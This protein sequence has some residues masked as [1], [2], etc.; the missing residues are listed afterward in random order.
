MALPLCLRGRSHGDL[1]RYQARANQV[2]RLLQGQRH[3]TP[4]RVIGASVKA[5]EHALSPSAI[6]ESITNVT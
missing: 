3:L 4:A 2:R 6:D 5:V 1:D